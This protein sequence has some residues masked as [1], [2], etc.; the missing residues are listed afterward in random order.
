MK[1]RNFLT[2]LGTTATVAGLSACSSQSDCAVDTAVK[3]QKTIHWTMV[4]TWPKNFQGLGEGAEYLARL[5]N[6][7]SGNRLKIRVLGAGE[8]VPAL[9]VFDA[10]SAGTAQMGQGAS[11]YWKGKMPAAPFFSSVPFGLTAQE[12][13]AWLLKGDGL[14]LWEKLYQPHGVIPRPAGNTGVQMAGWFN[15]EINNIDDL[16][17]LKMRI[18][19]LGGEV[20]KR[21]GGVPVLLPGSEVFTALE[22]GAIDAAEWVGPYNDLAFGLYKAA[23]YY[24]YPGWHEPGST[25]EAIINQ[26]ALK[27]LPED[28]QEIVLDACLIANHDM[29][30]DFTA[31]NFEALNVLKQ[32]HQVDVRR[33]PDEVLSKLKQLSIEV[34]KDNVGQDPLSQ[35]IYH[36]YSNFKE[37]V[38]SWTALADLS[39]LQTRQ[40]I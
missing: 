1:R 29:L 18:P 17:G 10:V 19:G 31:K 26:K 7:M 34:V 8:L 9:Q 23:K 35:E 15:K 36:S 3:S 6:K 39:Y 24:Y 37:Q 21:A 33:L 4:T 32:Q 16:K 25:M 11:Y 40:S 20:L 13:N 2:A 14:K 22:R 38:Q 27:A 30:S 12:M 5:I 28:L